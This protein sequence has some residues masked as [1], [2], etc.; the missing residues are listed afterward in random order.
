M[1]RTNKPGRRRTTSPPPKRLGNPQ[2]AKGS[3]MGIPKLSQRLEIQ[4]HRSRNLMEDEQAYVSGVTEE[5]DEEE[6]DE[7]AGGED[8][9]LPES[10]KPSDERRYFSHSD[11]RHPLRF[12]GAEKYD[13]RACPCIKQNPSACSFHYPNGHPK[14]TGVLPTQNQQPRGPPS[15]VTC[16]VCTA[17]FPCLECANTRQQNHV[18]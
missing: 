11:E 9:L 8:W 4:Q 14:H 16:S 1:G 18:S 3:T 17:E 15:V 2:G 7:E 6:V 13:G 12:F 10:A 5:V